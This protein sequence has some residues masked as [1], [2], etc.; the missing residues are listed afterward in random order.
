MISNSFKFT[1]KGWIKVY[2]DFEE[3]NRMMSFKV[4]D[5]GSGIKKEDFGRLFWAFNRGQDDKR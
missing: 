5:S 3:E 2:V 1:S 4:V